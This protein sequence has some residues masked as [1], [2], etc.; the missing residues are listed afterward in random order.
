MKEKWALIGVSI[1]LCLVF[2]GSLLFLISM[3]RDKGTEDGYAY[4][5]QDGI[6]VKTVSLEKEEVF[7][8]EGNHGAFNKIQVKDGS[9]GVTE[10]SCPDFLCGQMGYISKGPIPITCLPNR[11]VIEVGNGRETEDLDGV[12]Y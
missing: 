2:A 7:L 3:G 11:L 5:Y 6:L 8:I 9:I 12:V 1:F 10:A 4:I